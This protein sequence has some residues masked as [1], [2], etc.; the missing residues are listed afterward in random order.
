MGGRE[1]G[2]GMVV[3]AKRDDGLTILHGALL[4]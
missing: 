3:A 4:W 2:G 1:G